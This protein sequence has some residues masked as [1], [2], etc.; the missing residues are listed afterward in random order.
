M[1]ELHEWWGSKLSIHQK[2]LR[3]R[4]ERWF[5]S[6]LFYLQPN[7]LFTHP[8]GAAEDGRSAR[9]LPRTWESQHGVPGCR[10]VQPQLLEQ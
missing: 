10:L 9:P 1:S 8:G 5:E 3:P 7:I 2:H 6:Q 4:W